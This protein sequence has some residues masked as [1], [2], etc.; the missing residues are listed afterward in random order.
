MEEKTQKTE[1]HIVMSVHPVRINLEDCW[2][3]G[4]GNIC[5]SRDVPTFV[6]TA[7]L[8]RLPALSAPAGSNGTPRTSRCSRCLQEVSCVYVA[9]GGVHTSLFSAAVGCSGPAAPTASP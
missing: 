7:L 1:K 3:Q 8:V 6:T 9:V 5:N 2:G 4:S